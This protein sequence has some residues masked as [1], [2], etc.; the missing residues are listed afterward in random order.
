MVFESKAYGDSYYR[1]E[2]EDRMRT[3]LVIKF[4]QNI[5]ADKWYKVKVTGDST[6]DEQVQRRL[7]RNLIIFDEIPNEHYR[8]VTREEHYFEPKKK[9][10]QRVKNALKYVFN[11]KDYV[12]YKLDEGDKK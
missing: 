10:F 7:Y 1:E 4:G 9:F 6:F 8:I 12:Y 3:D 5:D 2:L 11:K